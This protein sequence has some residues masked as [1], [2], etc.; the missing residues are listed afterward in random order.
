[1]QEFLVCRGP[2]SR[3]GPGAAT[4]AAP[5]GSQPGAAGTP[6]LP[7]PS[8]WCLFYF[9]SALQAITTALLQQFVLRVSLC[10]PSRCQ[11]SAQHLRSPSGDR[12]ARRHAGTA[13]GQV[14]A[15]SAAPAPAGQVTSTSQRG[16][17][18]CPPT[19]LPPDIALQWP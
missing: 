17:Q 4:G 2:G 5:A 11:G 16:A 6:T 15:S 8:S 18:L 10:S 14:P 19:L 7:A 13:G 1:M 12:T 9:P 3:W